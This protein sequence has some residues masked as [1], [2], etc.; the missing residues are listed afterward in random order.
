MDMHL[1]TS[2]ITFAECRRGVAR[3]RQS[4][5]ISAAEERSAMRVV[6]EFHRRCAVVPVGPE[7]LDR[8]GRQ[9]PV[10]PVRS[11]DGIH[12]ASLEV[13][14]VLRRAIKV[15]TRDRRVRDTVARMGFPLA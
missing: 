11:L 12:L 6:D 7:V 3:A 8:V 14:G 2:A 9:F 1:V 15:V 5:R 13:L 10:E 4:A